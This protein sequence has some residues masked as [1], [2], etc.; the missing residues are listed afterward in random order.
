MKAP[1]PLSLSLLLGFPL[2]EPPQEEPPESGS[3]AESGVEESE[4]GCR[5]AGGSGPAFSTT[6]T[7]NPEPRALFPV[8]WPL[9]PSSKMLRERTTWGPCIPALNPSSLP[10]LHI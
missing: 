10:T 3:G 6:R 9:C 5:A 4:G 8:L 2:V 7:A 1:S